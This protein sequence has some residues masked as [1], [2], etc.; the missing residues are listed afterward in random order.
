MLM[1]KIHPQPSPEVIG[2]PISQAAVPP[3]APVEPQIPS[4]LLRSGPSSKVVMRINSAAGVISAA[5]TP[6]TARAPSSAAVVPDRPAAREASANRVVPAMNRRRRPS[7]SAARPP[8]RSRPPKLSRYALS[9]HCRSP[10]EKLRS[11]STDGSATTTIAESRMTMKN[12]VQ[13]SASAFQRRGSGEVV[14]AQSYQLIL[15]KEY[16]YLHQDHRRSR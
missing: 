4:A 6:C 8:S 15:E 13:S 3:I 14:I 11:A 9:T 2:P 12:A 16:G 10:V 5:A 7:R 1:K